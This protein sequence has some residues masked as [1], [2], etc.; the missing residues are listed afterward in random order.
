MLCSCEVS[1]DSSIDELR[2]DDPETPTGTLMKKIQFQLM[3]SSIRPPT[4]G[5]IASASA[6][7]PAQIPIAV[8][9][10]RGGNVRVMI[11]SV[12]GFISAAP[13]PCTTRAP[14]RKPRSGE[15]HASDESVKIA[16]PTTKMRRRP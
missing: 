12:A 14:I 6:D 16:S 15:P 5:P 8:P 11:E 13:T 7:T 2:D 10:C 9:R 1:R 4:S 3:C